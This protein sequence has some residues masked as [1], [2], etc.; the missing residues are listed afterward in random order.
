M[1]SRPLRAALR[2]LRIAVYRKTYGVCPERIF[3]H[4]TKSLPGRNELF[5]KKNPIVFRWKDNRVWNGRAAR[6]AQSVFFLARN[7]VIA[8]FEKKRT[9]RVLC[10]ASLAKKSHNTAVFLITAYEN[11]NVA[12]FFSPP[13]PVFNNTRCAPCVQSVRCER[14]RVQCGV[15]YNARMEALLWVFVFVLSLFAL[16]KG[17]QWFLHGA[18]RI[19]IAFGLS[20]FVIGVLIV[21]IGTSFPELVSS[22]AAILRDVPEIVVAN[23]VGSN[24]ANILL[25]IGA[26]A[27]IG[28]KLQ[29]T[30]D[31]IDLE[32]PLLAVSTI[33]F[34][35]IVMDGEVHRIEAILLFSAYI[36]YLLYSLF[37]G[38]EESVPRA[39]EEKTAE[40]Q[41]MAYQKWGAI[42]RFFYFLIAAKDYILFAV[43]VALVL[44]GAK[45]LIGSVIALSEIFSIAPGVIS[46]TAIALGTS[47]PELFVSARAVLAGKSEVAVGNILGSNAFNAL[48]VVGI[49]G[50]FS[51]LPIDE[52]TFTIGIPAM[53]L[54]TLLFIITGISRKIH[55]WEGMMFLI[56]YTLFIL[57]L[58][59]V[60]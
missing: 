18:E 6:G 11:S 20:P 14:W 49:P 27:V 42:S 7:A 26:A 36:I 43:G 15:V 37:S 2:L 44:A 48:M 55:H 35:G 41:R 28:R 29:V 58:F 8:R 4:N 46:I 39:A 5:H 51:A 12:H 30:K 10:A 32:L 33:L 9:L 21:G 54:V 59:G 17:S 3:S 56:V 22:V 38:E 24:I 1:K 45:Y 13:L 50:M 53:A 31:L 40:A 23:A 47:L 25:V 57:K 52:K 60:V 19:G 34:L 16:V